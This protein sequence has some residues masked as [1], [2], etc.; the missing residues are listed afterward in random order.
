MSE[1]ALQ[2]VV[3]FV[4]DAG[5]EL[6]ERGELLRLRQ[7]GA[8]RFPLGLEPGLARDVP[9]D[10]HGADGLVIPV[11]ERRHRHHE[12]AAEARMLERAHALGGE[13]G[14]GG[15]GPLGQVGPH[16]LGERALQELG[17]G[18]AEAHR[19]GIVHLH[20]PVLAIGYHDEVHERV[21]RVLQ[22]TPLA[23]HL[24]EELDVLDAV[25]ELAPEV[26]GEVQP[27]ARL[28]L[29]PPFEDQRPERASPAAQGCDE[30]RLAPPVR[31]DA[32]DLWLVEAEASRRGC[33][34]VAGGDLLARISDRRVGRGHQAERPI[35]AVVQP[36]GGAL[37]ADVPVEFLE[38]LVERDAQPLRRGD[39]SPERPSELPERGFVRRPGPAGAGWRG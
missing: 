8:E 10:E 23:E 19:E 24:L 20:D 12:V 34:G 37:G 3:D 4:R 9:G 18:A 22:Q 16:E 2:R 30:D 25:R 7:P 28:V 29:A 14:V 32:E 13:V 1:H 38:H 21:E 35:P 5:D 33:V 31:L 36:D 39:A 6:P 15:R 27:V 17:A 11:D 26:T